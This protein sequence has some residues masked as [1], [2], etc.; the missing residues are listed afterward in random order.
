[1]TRILVLSDTHLTAGKDA[2]D[3]FQN[4]ETYFQTADLIIHA[5]DHTGS[6]FYQAL[7]LMGNL[8]SVCGNMDV[9]P[10]RNDLPDQI[11]IQKDGV[12]IGVIHGWSSAFGLPERVYRTWA[13]PKPEVLI[14][15]HSHQAYKR[16]RGTTLLFNPGSPTAPHGPEP[17]V[18][19]LEIDRGAVK[20]DLIPLQERSG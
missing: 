11:V 16:Q 10:L 3:L 4:L 1:M 20:A 13:D 8:I 5:G 15:G 18:G 2:G 7:A 14:F 9:F 19:W 17:T 12:R 6:S